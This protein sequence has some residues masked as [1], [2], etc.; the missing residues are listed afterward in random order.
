MLTSLFFIVDPDW[1]PLVLRLV[2]GIA[3]AFHGYPKLFKA[4]E[5]FVGWLESIGFKP[6]LFW[7]WLVGITE[8]I[9]GIMIVLGFITEVVA[10]AVVIEFLVILIKIRWG[11]H[12][13]VSFNGGPSW[14]LDIVYLV[15]ALSLLFSG[16]G[17]WSLEAY[18][19]YG[20]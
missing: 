10:L 13:Y 1:A 6:G 4:R 17:N 8:F 16:S 7:A 19:L 15:V 12:P 11:K 20:Y 2:L 5:Q 3:L 9:G 18:L 14:E